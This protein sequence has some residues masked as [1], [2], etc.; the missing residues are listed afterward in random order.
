MEEKDYPN[1]VYFYPTSL[2]QRNKGKSITDKKEKIEITIKELKNEKGE[3]ILSNKTISLSWEVGYEFIEKDEYVKKE[4]LKSILNRNKEVISEIKPS[5][6]KITGFEKEIE[7]ND[8]TIME[9]ILES[10]EERNWLI[11]EKNKLEK[12]SE[13]ERNKHSYTIEDIEARLKEIKYDESENEIKKILIGL[14][15]EAK[16]INEKTINY[17]TK[18]RKRITLAITIYLRP[19]LL[20]INKPEEYLDLNSLI[21][22]SRY[23]MN[24]KA[25]S[26]V[27]SN[28]RFY[29]DNSLL[30]CFYITKEHTIKYNFYTKEE[31]EKR[32]EEEKKEK[33]EREQ[34]RNNI[35]CLGSRRRKIKDLPYL[36]EMITIKIT[37]MKYKNEITNEMI[38]NNLNY[39]FEEFCHVGIIDLQRNEESTLMKILKG[40]LQPTEGKIE[41]NCRNEIDIIDEETINNLPNDEIVFEYIEKV[42]NRRDIETSECL[43]CFEIPKRKHREKIK[44][45][46]REEK[47]MLLFAK[48]YRKRPYVIL[49]DNVINNFDRELIYIL[50]ICFNLPGPSIITNTKNQYFY[51][52]LCETIL[53]HNKDGSFEIF[54]GEYHSYCNK[55]MKNIRDKIQNDN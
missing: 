25:I 3:I 47:I 52:E 45:L 55:V 24:F 15:F 8:K 5:N 38:I 39:K 50:W 13:E 46:T 20:I 43:E 10:D 27:S 28:D 12:E 32:T 48:S 44:E 22:L 17:S 29:L 34:L 54:K 41:N 9:T 36:K 19:D 7:G 11:K 21:W 37:N 53:I 23:F 14:G 18:M 51:E 1:Y 26:I 6:I 33:K 31:S 2:Q 40:K 42:T 4:L 16:E 30:S 35:N 49:V